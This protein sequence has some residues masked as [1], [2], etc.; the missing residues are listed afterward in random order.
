MQTRNEN[1]IF[2]SKDLENII[3][4]ENLSVKKK[5]NNLVLNLN[6]KEL[7]VLGYVKS[8]KKTK[9]TIICDEKTL[10]DLTW[11]TNSN[12][13]VTLLDKVVCG[14]DLNKDLKKVKLKQFSENS[15]KVTLVFKKEN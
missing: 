6:K 13:A 10:L 12:I 11:P 5:N 14:F 3:D 7:P 2:I 15:Y 1:R 8:F 4:I 9:F